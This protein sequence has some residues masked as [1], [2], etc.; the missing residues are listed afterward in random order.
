M[1]SV[2]IRILKSALQKGDILSELKCTWRNSLK[3]TLKS[4]NA[5]KCVEKEQSRRNALK[6]SNQTIKEKCVEKE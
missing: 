1:K 4:V 3:M 6:R 5:E 2:I